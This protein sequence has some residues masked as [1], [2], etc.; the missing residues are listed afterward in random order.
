M[1]TLT[2]DLH[3]TQAQLREALA[4]STEA[5][6]SRLRIEAQLSSV[7]AELTDAQARVNERSQALADVRERQGD[8]T[9]GAVRVAELEAALAAAQNDVAAARHEH[10]AVSAQ[11]ASLE[12]ELR[13]AEARWEAA[14]AEAD[15][16]RQART[17]CE[18]HMDDQL[19]QLRSLRGVLT[20][21]TAELGQLRGEKDH[22][23][24]ERR[25]ILE[26]LA[27]FEAHLQRVRLETDQYGAE[28]RALQAE[29]RQRSSSDAVPS[30]VMER[31]VR[32][33]VAAAVSAL[34][35]RWRAERARV[36]SLVAQKA[37]LQRELRAQTWLY[38]R[39]LTR[40]TALAPH[41]A[42]YGGTPPPAVAPRRW[43]VVLTAVLFAVRC[44]ALY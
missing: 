23:W 41:L 24:L 15:D 32:T 14:R 4:H 35:P 8:T 12:D 2:D 9:Q 38:Q 42:A 16:A 25:Q 3:A 20:E 40:L 29:K 30:A 39:L 1:R 10:R 22:L 27:A 26:Q 44:R 11:R 18:A 28:L 21:Q 43:R 17:A 5:T 31:A 37:F 6:A 36:E 34:A 19:A 13:A 33:Q 7:L